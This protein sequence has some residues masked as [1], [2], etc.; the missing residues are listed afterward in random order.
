MRIPHA[1]HPTGGVAAGQRHLTLTYVAAVDLGKVLTRHMTAEKIKPNELARRCGLA[2]SVV[3]R[4]ISG[5]AQPTPDTL[6]RL[7]QGT[8]IPLLTL[9]VVSGIFTADELGAR[10]IPLAAGQ[11]TDDELLDELRARIRRDTPPPPNPGG[12]RDTIESRPVERDSTT[13]GTKSRRRPQ[14]PLRAVESSG[15]GAQLV[16]RATGPGQA[17]L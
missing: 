12:D 10:I 2:P 9:I 11:L 8:G 7:H 3:S 13:H 15:A 16:A 5:E 6:R 17:G 14:P 4:I 1:T